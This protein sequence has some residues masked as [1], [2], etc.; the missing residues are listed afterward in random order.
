M[1]TSQVKALLN[2]LFKGRDSVF[3]AVEGFNQD[4]KTDF[5]LWLLE[6]AYEH[7]HF[8]GYGLNQPIEN[9]PFEWNL[10]SDM[11][12]LERRLVSWGKKYMYFLD[13][14]G[15]TAPRAT[16]WGKLNLELIKKL[17]V[18]R[19]D[20]LSMFGASIGDVDRRIISPN[21]LDVHIRKTSLTTATVQHLQKRV[22]LRLTNIPPT[23][24]K[25]F[26]HKVSVFTLEPKSTSYTYLDADMKLAL[27]WA[28][29]EKYMGELS[30][31]GRFNSI[32]RGLLKWYKMYS[33]QVETTKLEVP[34]TETVDK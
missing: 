23:S 33:L 4:G 29:K 27:S 32:R 12:T 8:K 16:P 3:I 11:Q 2:L 9:A 24:I 25:F 19:K 1:Q 21:Y 14:L 26:E 30:K 10:I 20:L 34:S 13:E 7:G 5:I 28:R 31:Q 15:K 17:E 6:N 18:K 22:S